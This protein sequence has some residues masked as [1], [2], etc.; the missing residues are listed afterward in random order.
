[1]EDIIAEIMNLMLYGTDYKLLLASDTT[2]F[3]TT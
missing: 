2:T 1:M 3:Y